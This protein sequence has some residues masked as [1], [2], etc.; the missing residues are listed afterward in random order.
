MP[1]RSTYLAFVHAEQAVALPQLLQQREDPP[2]AVHASS[3][4]R[5]VHRFC[6]KSPNLLSE[7][8]QKQMAF[9]AALAPKTSTLSA[10]C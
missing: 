10:V 5:D 9:R 3:T 7:R 2:G 8:C 1:A 6:T 4:M